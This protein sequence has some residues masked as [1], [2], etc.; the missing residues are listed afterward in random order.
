MAAFT[1]HTYNPFEELLSLADAATGKGRCSRG[2]R[3]HKRAYHERVERNADVTPEKTTPIAPPVDIF[4][5]DESYTIVASVAGAS[6]SSIS[7]DYDTDTRR[8]TVSGTTSG[9][10]AYYDDGEYRRKFLKVGERRVGDFR[11][12]ISLPYDANV[13]ED[14]IKAHLAN[15]LLKVVLPKASQPEK[16]KIV[17]EIDRDDQEPAADNSESSKTETDNE[18]AEIS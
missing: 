14:S 2:R 7:I 10:S 8:L 5:T 18:N 4:S 1:M 11:R 15:G 3:P 13:V 6:E 9:T 16:K 12:V 17:I